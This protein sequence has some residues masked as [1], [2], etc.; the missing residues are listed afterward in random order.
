MKKIIISLCGA[1][2]LGVSGAALAKDADQIAQDCIMLEMQIDEFIQTVP[3][4]S[5]LE[6][7]K[8]M[9]LSEAP[10]EK[11]AEHLI[12]NK[13]QD[14]LKEVNKSKGHITKV[15][16]SYLKCRQYSFKVSQFINQINEIER[17]I[18]TL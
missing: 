9:L 14:A 6:C 11:A 16:D 13:Y 8:E 18:N 5:S 10:L 4:P 17:E 15:K 7:K 1:L 3:A 12:F 2:A